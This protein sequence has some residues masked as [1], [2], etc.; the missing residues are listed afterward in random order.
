MGTQ[1]SP[2]S[3]GTKRQPVLSNPT[4]KTMLDMTERHQNDQ[5][6]IAYCTSSPAGKDF[7]A[8]NLA[9]KLHKSQSDQTLMGCTKQKRLVQGGDTSQHTAPKGSA[10]NVLVPHT[11][12]HPHLRGG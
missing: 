4:E 11:A 6:T 3:A 7:K 1:G 2:I 12:A 10:I 5:C 8:A 9:S